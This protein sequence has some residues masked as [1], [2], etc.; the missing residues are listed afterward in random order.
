MIT[1]PLF[2]NESVTETAVRH[3]DRIRKLVERNKHYS[4]VNEIDR[5]PSSQA[6]RQEISYALKKVGTPPD[7]ADI[8][9]LIAVAQH[10]DAEFEELNS[11]ESA[12]VSCVKAKRGNSDYL[13]F[14]NAVDS[15]LTEN[16]YSHRCDVHESGTITRHIYVSSDGTR[17]VGISNNDVKIAFY[18]LKS[19]FGLDKLVDEYIK[20]TFFGENEDIWDLRFNYMVNSSFRKVLFPVTGLVIPVAVSNMI[21]MQPISDEQ[22]FVSGLGGAAIGFIA[23]IVYNYFRKRSTENKIEEAKKDFPFYYKQSGVYAVIDAFMPEE[24]QSQIAKPVVPI[25]EKIESLD[26]RF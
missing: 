12:I 4:A 25:P 10:G 16:G 1:K 24:S 6:L 17:V 14:R 15:L 20:Y 21:S 2:P 11:L 13:T 8:S 22:T 5:P 18:L 26:F 3:A 19:K 7:D 9:A 23:A